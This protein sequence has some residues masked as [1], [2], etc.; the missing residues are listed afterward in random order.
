[1]GDAIKNG[2]GN[3]TNFSGR[4]SRSLFWWW[5]LFVV[6]ITFGISIISGVVFTA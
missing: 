3:L 6:I 4:D 2:F 5:I 1:M